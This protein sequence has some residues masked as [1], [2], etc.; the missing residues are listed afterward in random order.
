[1]ALDDA[2]RFRE[3]DPYTDRLTDLGG[4]QIRVDRSRFEVDINRPR[5]Q[6]V[7]LDP[8]AAWGYTVF[9]TPPSPEMVERSLRMHDDFYAGVTRHLDGLKDG[10]VVLDLHSYNHRRSGPRT[11][12]EPVEDNPDVNVGTGTVDRS[13]WGGLIDRFMTDL[14]DQRVAGH[15]LDVGENVKFRGGHFPSWVNRRYPERGCALAIEFKKLFMDEWTG[16]LDTQHLGQL[17]TAL[18]ATVPGLRAA[19]MVRS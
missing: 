11:L 15:R 4:T 12:P 18:A 8:D 1:M 6:A 3:E 13:R 17:R 2:T 14:G 7:Y 5:H 9:S 10:F 16:E 19:F